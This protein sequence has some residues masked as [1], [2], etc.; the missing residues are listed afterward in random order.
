VSQ[1][2]RRHRHRV[3]VAAPGETDGH[4]DLSQGN[5]AT[6]ALEAV[7]AIGKFR[8]YPEKS[9][10]AAEIHSVEPGEAEA[11]LDALDGLFEFYFVQPAEMRR[12]RDELMAKLN[13]TWKPVE[14]VPQLG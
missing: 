11:I 7:R 4:D 13:M 10:R 14:T 6:G 3:A 8:E 9:T 2:H 12:K 1:L 5:A